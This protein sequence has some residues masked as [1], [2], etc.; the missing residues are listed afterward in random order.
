MN[1]YKE[2]IIELP[3]SEEIYGTFH[4][5]GNEGSFPVMILERLSMASFKLLADE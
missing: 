4:L 1:P 2:I 5:G 3:D